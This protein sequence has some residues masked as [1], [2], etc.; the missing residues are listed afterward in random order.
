M[1]CMPFAFGRKPD[2]TSDGG[3]ARH[4][5]RSKARRDWGGEKEEAMERK[6]NEKRCE[7]E[8]INRARKASP[9]QSNGEEWTVLADDTRT[10]PTKNKDRTDEKATDSCER[11]RKTEREEVLLLVLLVRLLTTINAALAKTCPL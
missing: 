1:R 7:G 9:R 8:C 10:L 2:A 4:P 3:A 11:R 5:P 6:K